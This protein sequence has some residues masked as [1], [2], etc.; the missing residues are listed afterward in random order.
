MTTLPKIDAME[1]IQ[2]KPFDD[3]DWLFEVKNDGCRAVASSQ[4]RQNHE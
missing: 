3:P 4:W 1:L 2:A